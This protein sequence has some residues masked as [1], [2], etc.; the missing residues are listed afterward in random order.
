VQRLIGRFIALVLLVAAAGGAYWWMRASGGHAPARAGA[1]PPPEVGVVTVSQADIPLPLQYAG[2]VAG[3]RVVEVRAQVGGIL[4]KREYQ[5]GATVKAGDVLFRID[6]RSYEAALAR[7]NAQ[8]AQSQATLKAAEEN[9]VRVN[10]LATRQFS[11]QKALEDAVAARDQARAALQ[12]AEADQQT[13]KLNLEYTVVK[14]PVTGPTSIGTPPEGILVLAQQT[15][16]TTIT[17]VDPAYVVFST[18]DREFREFQE[19]NRTRAQPLTAEDITVRLQFGDGTMNREVG[20]LEAQSRTVDPRTGTILIRAVFPNA[21][22]E[23]LPGQFVR[24]HIAGVTMPNAVVV[25]KRAIGQGPQGPF[26]YVVDAHSTAQVRPVQLDRELENGW[27]VRG[28]LKAGER[29]VDDGVIRVRP[30]AQVKVATP[31][32][33]PAPAAEGRS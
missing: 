21:D 2:R 19:M 31:A 20:R 26:V 10:S 12:A 32:A 18:T 15:L 6:P 13:A 17:Q 27:I 11:S 16:L 14:A 29:I 3:F 5:E 9:Y 22:G 1:P 24:V 25:P 30:G 28:G 4:L 33:A 23:L 7:A 8:I